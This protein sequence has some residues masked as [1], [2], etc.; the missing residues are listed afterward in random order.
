MNTSSSAAASE[1]KLIAGK[2]KKDAGSE[3]FKKGNMTEGMNDTYPMILSSKG[4]THSQK[5]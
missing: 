2:K 1:E 4:G 3:A 5:C